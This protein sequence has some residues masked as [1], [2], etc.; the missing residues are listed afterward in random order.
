MGLDE[1]IGTIPKILEHIERLEEIALR[2][3]MDEYITPERVEEEF[4]I[5]ISSQAKLRSDRMIPYYKPKGKILYLRREIIEY[6]EKHRIDSIE[7]KNR[8]NRT[9]RRT[10]RKT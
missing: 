2:T 3:Y 9:N 5:S 7:L 4:G 1:A 6:I 8:S 10:N